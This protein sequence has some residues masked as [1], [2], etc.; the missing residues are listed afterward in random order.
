[1]LYRLVGAR[2]VRV[3]HAAALHVGQDVRQQRFL[4]R[5][6]NRRGPECAATAPRSPWQNGHVER[7][8]GSVWR[9]CLDYIVVEVKTLCTAPSRRI[10]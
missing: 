10:Y 6:G 3:D 8:I 9:E 5:V 1:M 2:F 4:I 7:V